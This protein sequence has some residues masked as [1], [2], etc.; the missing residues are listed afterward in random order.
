MLEEEKDWFKRYTKLTPLERRKL[1][2]VVM[3]NDV[4][5]LEIINTNSFDNI[6][7]ASGTSTPI[8]IVEDIYKKLRGE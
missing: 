5:E 6:F 4:R 7:I 1:D 3:I 2:K 8:N